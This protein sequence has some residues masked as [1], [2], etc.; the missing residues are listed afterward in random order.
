MLAPATATWAAPFAAYYLFLQNRVVYHRL[1]TEKYMG[2]TANAAE[3]TKDPLYVA[4]RA[5]LNFIEN[6]PIAF[7]VAL[8]AELNGANRKYISYGLAALLAFRVSHVELGMMKKDSIGLG[9]PAG[10]YGTQ[11]VIASLAGYVAYL[12]KDYW[13]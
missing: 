5:Q 12:V 4:T 13:M 9:R 1:K 6:V 3:G 10:Y 7:L 11:A 8:L 2:D